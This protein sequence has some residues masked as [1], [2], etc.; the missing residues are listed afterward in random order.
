MKSISPIP[1]EMQASSSRCT[2][3][4]TGSRTPSGTGALEHQSQMLVHQR[5]RERGAVVTGQE[6]RWVVLDERRADHHLEHP[7]PL[8][9]VR[10]EYRIVKQCQTLWDDYLPARRA[11]RGGA[12][13]PLN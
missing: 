2:V 9:S 4:V 11:S 6:R 7:G 5:R 8:E 12:L 13:A 10:P 3:A 1:E